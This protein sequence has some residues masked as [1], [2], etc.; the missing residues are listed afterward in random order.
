MSTPENNIQDRGQHF[1]ALRVSAAL[2]IAKR[3]VAVQLEKVNSDTVLESN[4][5]KAKAWRFSSLPVPIREKLQ[6]RAEELHYRNAEHL[7]SAPITAWQPSVSWA[8]SA[9]NN[10]ER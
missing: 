2:G 9:R 6:V 3:T 5:N 4:G 8:Q 7:L 1:T 10:Q